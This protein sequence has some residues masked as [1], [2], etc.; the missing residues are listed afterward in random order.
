M[1]FSSF[2]LQKGR[3]AGQNLAKPH[4]KKPGFVFTMALIFL[5]AGGW[6]THAFDSRWPG[7]ILMALG[8]VGMFRCYLLLQGKDFEQH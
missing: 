8:C 3:Q 2:F 7:G 6:A 5:L 4:E 1:I